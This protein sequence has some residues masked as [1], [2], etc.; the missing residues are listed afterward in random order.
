[1]EIIQN[2]KLPNMHVLDIDQLCNHFVGPE[3]EFK[4]IGKVLAGFSLASK[5]SAPIKV[6]HILCIKS[7]IIDH[8]NC[9]DFTA[10]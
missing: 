10:S 1:M 7:N 9:A 5:P 4:Y 2:K 8:V 3:R 6:S